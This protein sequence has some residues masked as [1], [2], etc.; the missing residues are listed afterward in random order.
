MD[1]TSFLN[2]RNA[3]HGKVNSTPCITTT[4]SSSNIPQTITPY[5]ATTDEEEDSFSGPRAIGYIEGLSGDFEWVEP[6]H[7]T[8]FAGNGP[9]CEDIVQGTVGN[10]WFFAALLCIVAKQPEFIK[11]LF[12]DPK[13]SAGKYTC[14]LYSE[15]IGEPQDIEVSIKLPRRHGSSEFLFSKP[16]MYEGK[17]VM[18]VSVLEKCLAKMRGSYGAL[19]KD[20]VA[21]GFFELG[22]SNDSL[23]FVNVLQAAAS[24]QQDETN[25]TLNALRRASTAE[26]WNHMTIHKSVACSNHAFE[27]SFKRLGLISSHAYSIMT[28]YEECNLR[29]VALADPLTNPQNPTGACTHWSGD[30]S[31]NSKLWTSRLRNATRD[32]CPRPG[33]FWMSFEDFLLNFSNVVSCEFL[34]LSSPISGQEAM[35]HCSVKGS[36]NPTMNP[37]TWETNPQFSFHVKAEG[38]VILLLEQHPQEPTAMNEI[39]LNVF[40]SEQASHA[41]NKEEKRIVSSNMLGHI[42]LVRAGFLKS[43]RVHTAVCLDSVSSRYTVMASSRL[44]CN[45]KFTIHLW[46]PGN[47]QL[48]KPLEVFSTCTSMTGSAIELSLM[49][50]V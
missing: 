9:R 50:G 37:N 7:V 2:V 35:V 16:V 28:T 6:E 19:H 18:W 24:S 48:E 38:H 21:T 5:S 49:N 15:L 26:I 39:A 22:L 14:R 46:A 3:V 10:C 29:L 45:D 32:I 30:Y 4:P 17:A 12:I 47:L 42:C 43:R 13:P 20:E 44:P 23:V 8:L 41:S 40:Q 25:F 1:H 31:E 33:T 11:A 27:G 36:W 34:E